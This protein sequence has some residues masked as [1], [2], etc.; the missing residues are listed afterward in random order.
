MTCTMPRKGK[1][2]IYKM[3][4]LPFGTKE[5]LFGMGT[6]ALDKMPADLMNQ[7]MSG[8]GS[9]PGIPGINAP[10]SGF[11]THLL[12]GPTIEDMQAM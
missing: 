7:M 10:P 4:R 3:R 8:A 9:Y 2:I 11:P 5:R 1:S 12:E 6:Q